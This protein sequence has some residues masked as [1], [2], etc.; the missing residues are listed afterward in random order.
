MPKGRP[1]KRTKWYTITDSRREEP[2]KEQ[3]MKIWPKPEEKKK[4]FFGKKK[5]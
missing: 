3:G 2:H 4:G 5:K 1:S